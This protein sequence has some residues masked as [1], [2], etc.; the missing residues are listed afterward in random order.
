MKKTEFLFEAVLPGLPYRLSDE[1]RK[2][3]KRG[4]IPEE[5]RLRADRRASLTVGNKNIL[6]DTVMQKEE[7]A[8]AAKF[9]ARGSL[10]AFRETISAGYIPFENGIRIG[11][12]GSAVNEGGRVSAVH[13]I[14]SLVIRLPRDAGECALQLCSHL[15]DNTG[16]VCSCLIYSPS[17]VGKTTV[18]RSAARIFASPPKPCRVAVVDTREEIGAFLGGSGLTVDVLAGYPKDV[19]IEIAARTLNAELIIADEIFGEREAES[20]CGAVNC[21]IPILCSAH[22]DSFEEL[23]SRPGIKLLSEMKAFREYVRISRTDEPFVYEFDFDRG[24][25]C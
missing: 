15:T 18:L 16:K 4:I 14:T 5:I 2:I 19:G 13:N 24:A 7:I 23:I 11:V 8:S 3:R 12:S 25:E 6:L 22:A 10:Y 1:I 9:F 21:G 20:L 17:G